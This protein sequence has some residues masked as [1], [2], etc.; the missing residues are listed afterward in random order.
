VGIVTL[1]TLI[2]RITGV[3]VQITISA[4]LGATR[5][6]DAYQVAW[7]L[8]NMLR[9]FTAEG[10]M[11][12]AFLPTLTEV[13]ARDGKAGAIAFVSDFMGSLAWVLGVLCLLGILFMAPIIGLQMLGK[14][15]PGQPLLEQLRAFGTVLAGKA[16]FPPDVALAE[17]IARLMFPYL[18]LVSL[19][20]CMAAVLNLRGR[21]ALTASVSTFFNLT[22]LAASWACLQLGPRAWHQPERAALLF[23]CAVIL[24]GGVQVLVLLP[25]FR[26]LGFRLGFHL[27]L[28]NTDVRLALKR[29]GPGLLAGGIHPLNV[30]VSTALASQLGYGAQ[31]VLNNSN[32]LGELVLGLFAMSFATVSLPAMSRQAAEGDLPGVR[33][34]LSMAL[35]GTAF[36]AI[37][38][39]VGLAVLAYP[40]AAFLFQRGQFTPASVHWLA[41]TLPFQALGILFIATVRIS[42]QA[43]NAL[44]DYRSPAQSAVLQFSCNIVLSLLLMKPLGTRGMALANSLS[45]LVGLFYL[46][47][48]L[49]H[50]LGQLPYRPVLTGWALF[51][52]GSAAMGLLTVFGGRL[53]DVFT[54]H[55]FR[56]TGLRLFPLMAAA[57]LGYFALVKMLRV[58]EA[59]ELIAMIRRK[60]RSTR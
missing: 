42:N 58:Q 25:A 50:V 17:G 5:M 30:L 52:L 16:N 26:R 59:E 27:R 9:R 21:F 47:W 18:V 35:R 51:G 45:A 60:L 55:G 20:A 10:T 32:M 41:E 49:R 36:L 7:R 54:Y 39:A 3:A 1:M 40:I 53:V 37:P 19:T 56:G 23:A 13:E 34:N 22:F 11:T 44:K 57:S 12:S 24:G 6:G 15:A 29:M 14:L 48:R 4:V 46:E 43:L 31:V 8:P 33:T 2:S 38:A 28:K